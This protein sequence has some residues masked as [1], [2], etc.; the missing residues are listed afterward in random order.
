MNQ[1]A[2]TILMTLM[3]GLLVGCPAGQSTPPASSQSPTA[4]QPHAPTDIVCIT[5][6]HAGAE[7]AEIESAI[8]L[9]I[10]ST[11]AGIDGITSV[12]SICRNGELTCYVKTQPAKT[13]AVLSRLRTQPW[14]NALP[15]AVGQATIQQV[16]SVPAVQPKLIHVTRIEFDRA[17]MGS[18]GLTVA[19]GLAALK[20][21]GFDAHD[22]SPEN[23]SKLET[24][25]LTNASG[26]TV[27]LSAVASI[28]RELQSDTI[29]RQDQHRQGSTNP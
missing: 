2:V 14:A 29:V 28:S 23:L 8:A 26:S 3:A 24:I 15:A 4:S 20:A 21:S 19:D 25:V 6:E 17:R 13:A 18:L 9:P 10:E 1:L 16:A 11:V 7:P 5:V 27:P 12:T 22:Q